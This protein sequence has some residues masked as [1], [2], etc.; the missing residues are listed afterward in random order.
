MPSAASSKIS[1]LVIRSAIVAA[2]GGLLFG[3]DTAVIS[4]TTNNLRSV[5][6]L[7][8]FGLGFTV[9]TA[10]IGTIIG[11][12]SAG[13]PAD[14]WGRK[15]ILLTIG[16]LYTV[17]ALGSALV[18]NWYLFMFFRLIGGI[19]VGGASVVAPI[20]TAEISP[21]RVRGRLVGL[22]QFNVVLGILLAYLSNYVLA[23]LFDYE[24]AWRWM[25]G[26]EA[27]P[28]MAFLLLALTIPESPRWLY[29]RGRTELARSIVER[30]T[31]S[32]Q[33]ADFEIGEIEQAL[34]QDAS[35]GKAPFFVPR[36]YRVILLAFAIAAFNQLSGINAIMYYAPDIFRMAGA[37]SDTA[38]LSSIAVGAMNLIATMTALTVIDRFGRRRLM[39]VGSIG[40]L[41]SL[42]AIAVVFFMSGESFSGGASTLVL[43]S[44]LV[45]I[46]AHAFGQGSVI[47]VFIS[48]IFPSRIRARGQALGSFTHWFFAAVISWSFPA[49]AGGLG[50]G[51]AF[52]LFLVCMVGQLVW[53]LTTMPETKGV[54]L[55]EMEE[56]LGLGSGR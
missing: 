15:S 21:A 11:A 5:F 45:F 25:F 12:M 17:S 46:A 32:R 26:I 37:G 27:V 34:K 55:E 2:L 6:D 44:L 22:V 31:S 19:G 48:E 7:S 3:F 53:V 39:I 41:I 56:R 40:Y 9:A 43:L 50:G 18:S 29:G 16:L 36:N 42:G 28:A 30:L 20:Y 35:M 14:I 51:W 52:T 49:I 54:P 1:P 47:W 24:V 8:E 23:K 38:F 10:L 13:R 33:E 4:G